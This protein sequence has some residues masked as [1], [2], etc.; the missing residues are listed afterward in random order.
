MQYT[1]YTYTYIYIYIC[2]INIFKKKEKTSARRNWVF[3][4]FLFNKLNVLLLNLYEIQSFNP[5][6]TNPFIDL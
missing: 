4:Y 5:I 2:N 6:S 1:R 3:L